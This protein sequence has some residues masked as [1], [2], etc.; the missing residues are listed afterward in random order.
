MLLT[1]ARSLKDDDE[2]MDVS[3][4]RAV[5][6]AIVDSSHSVVDD[7]EVDIEIVEVNEF[8]INAKEA[9]FLDEAL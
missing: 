9:S 2:V 7:K 3:M 1:E 5:D 6:V 4:P 8:A